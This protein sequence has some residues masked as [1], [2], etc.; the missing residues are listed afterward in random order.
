MVFWAG[1]AK[2][3]LRS[4]KLPTLVYFYKNAR[5][6]AV[7]AERYKCSPSGL[8]ACTDLL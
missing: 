3:S 1:I 4:L 5:T 2:V 8:R 7:E 6:H